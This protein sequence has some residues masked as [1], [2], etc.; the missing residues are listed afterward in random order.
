MA[1]VSLV[2]HRARV[3]EYN[4]RATF[5]KRCEDASHSQ[6]FR[7]REYASLHF[8]QIAFGVRRVLASLAREVKNYV[9]GSV[10]TKSAIDLR[11]L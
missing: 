2:S 4:E 6:S 3:I 11:I 10:A 9:D 5:K 1:T 8:A 7:E